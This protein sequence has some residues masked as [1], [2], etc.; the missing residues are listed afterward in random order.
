MTILLLALWSAP[1]HAGD[2]S[3]TAEPTL[4]DFSDPEV[5]RRVQLDLLQGL[6]DS[7]MYDDAL[8]VATEMRQQGV[9]DDRLDIL[10]GKVQSAKGMHN[11]AIDLLTALTRRSPRNA[12]AWAALGV[13]YADGERVP[14]AIAA[15][16]RAVKLNPKD[17][18]SLN[19]LG[20]LCMVGGKSDRAIEVFKQALVLDPASARTHNNL[21]FALA[22]AE[23]D[24]DALE[25]FRGGGTEA[26]ARYNLG[27]ACE[28]RNDTAS[29]LTQYQ[30]AIQIQPDYPQAKA[31]LARLLHQE[32][33]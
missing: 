1:A 6:Y 12:D 8:G 30:A 14:D 3:H 32:S 7:K 31:A 22:R 29:A 9:K 24:S 26:D 17:P 27:V 18:A 10:Q 28:L 4:P 16:E 15:L 20:Y 13:A 5:K 19:N 25:A 21:G 11:E 23:R 33:P 2:R